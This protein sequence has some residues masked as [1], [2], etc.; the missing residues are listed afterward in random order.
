MLLF[1]AIDLY[2]GNA[3]R[4]LRGDYNQMTIY[5]QSPLRVAQQFEAEGAGCLHLV[6]LEGAKD[7]TVPHLPLITEIIKKTNLFVEVGGGIRSDD[8]LA[9]YM[10]AG[11]HRAILGT[12]AVEDNDFLMRAVERYGE[13]IA[14][15][16]DVRDGYVSIR[17][18]TAESAYTTDEFVTK[19]EEAGVS[20]IICTDIS[21]DGAMKGTNCELYRHLSAITAMNITASGGVSS[22]ED[23]R[24]LKD[25][26]LYGAILGKALYEG[27][28]S[29]KDALAL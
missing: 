8:T 24:A 9:R 19:M 18:W 20:T 26:N 2:G 1:P 14:V 28:I 25:M 12:A 3:V 5:D 21:K 27:A 7:G 16:I 15:G 29:L 6:D 10:D 23:I 4:L 17:G 11:V 13:R 22:Y